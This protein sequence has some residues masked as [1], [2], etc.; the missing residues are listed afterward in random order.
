M[1]IELGSGPVRAWQGVQAALLAG[2]QRIWRRM[3]SLP[4]VVELAQRDPGRH[5]R[6]TTWCC[7]HGTLK[8]LRYR[9]TTPA[10][11]AEPML[12][13]YALINRAY[14][15]D[16]QQDKSV[17]G[18]YLE[19]GFDVYMIDWGVAVGRRPPPHAGALR[20][21][22]SQGGRRLRLRARIA[23][24]NLHLLGY[25]MG[26]TMSA[27]FTAL[28]P[29]RHQ[30]PHPPGGADRL[31]RQ[32]VAAESV[33][34]PRALRRRRLRRRVRQLSR[35]VPASLLLTDEPDSEPDR[36]EHH[37]LRTAG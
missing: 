6:R 21:R 8:L 33:G 16:L 5:H 26:G 32:G 29:D 35:L 9:R 30:D 37:V 3:L 14:I 4:R 23:R 34:R 11:Y 2:Q 12:F 13:C 31:R 36:Q 20:L 7:E 24:Q 1:E 28:Y 15:L 17:I 25:C 27:L 19:Q 18:R 10:R 22:L